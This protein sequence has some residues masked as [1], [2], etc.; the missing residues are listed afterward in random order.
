MFLHLYVHP[1]NLFQFS[2]LNDNFQFYSVFN[3]IY[4]FKL[5]NHVMT[6]GCNFGISYGHTTLIFS[7]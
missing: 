1:F 2:F 5:V 4:L 6:V 3:C 7:F